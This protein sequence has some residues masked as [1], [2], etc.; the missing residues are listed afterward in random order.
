MCSAPQHSSRMYCGTWVDFPHPVAP[1]TS[2]TWLA[3]MACVISCLQAASGSH[4]LAKLA[5]LRVPLLRPA[6]PNAC[7]VSEPSSKSNQVQQWQS[8]PADGPA[9]QLCCREALQL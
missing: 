5:E 1:A 9:K 2:S 3:A 4:E 6:L 7:P 8:A